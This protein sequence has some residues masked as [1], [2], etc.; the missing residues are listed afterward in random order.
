[1]LIGSNVIYYDELTS[2][3]TEA[4]LLLKTNEIKEG[5]VIHAGFQTAGRGQAGNSWESERGKNLLFSVIIYPDSVISGEQFLISIAFSLGICDFLDNYVR[6]SKIKWPNDIYINNDK[7]AGVLIENSILGKRMENSIIGIGLNLNQE[8]FPRNIAN[9]SSL[10][11]VTGRDYDPE[12]CLGQLLSCLDK[13]YKI[14][15]YGDREFLVCEYKSRLFRFGKWISF[16]SGK[17]VFTGRITDIILSG[18]LA[19]ERKEGGSASYSYGEI[20]Y[21]L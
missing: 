5:T 4:S 2:T 17:D 8:K 21:I 1:M 6:H 15:L 13:R 7:I 9:P 14:L 18:N 3:N 19:I 20:E 10:K 11:I 16:K 12:F